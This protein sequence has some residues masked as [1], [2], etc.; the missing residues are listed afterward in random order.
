MNIREQ[1]NEVI[2]GIVTGQILETF[3]K[4]YDEKVVIHDHSLSEQENKAS[5]RA[6]KERFLK[7]LDAYHGARATSV[8][9]DGHKSAVEWRVEITPKD[10]KRITLNQ[11]AF[12]T[13]KNGK[14]I[15]ETIYHLL[16]RV[17]ENRIPA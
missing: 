2:I 10:G 8:V 9:V 3:D 15:K 16:P 1:V 12:Q 5:I 13:W 11:L 6:H 17:E 14:I 4:Y 7:D